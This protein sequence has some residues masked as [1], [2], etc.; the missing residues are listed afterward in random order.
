[1]LDFD[2]AQ[3]RLIQAATMPA[4]SER[5]P[6]ERALGR[7][8]AETVYA[9]LDIP[10]ADNSA[11][12]G[13]AIRHAETQLD[14]PMPIQDHIY[15]GDEPMP[16]KPK[17]AIRLFTG[18]L[19]PDGADTVVMQEHCTEIEGSVEINRLPPAGANVRFRGEDMAK[20]QTIIA[21]GQTLNSR[22]L[23]ILA[24]QGCTHIDVYPVPKIGILSTGDE[25]INP[26]Q[27]LREGQIYNSNSPMLKGMIDALGAEAT[28][29]I[30][31]PD[32]IEA[33]QEALRQLTDSCD[34]VLTVGGV[35]VGDKDFVKP[36]IEQMGGRM[37]LWR[38][39]M[40]PGR[41]VTLAQVR[42]TP[43]IGLPGNPVSAYAIFLLMVSPL[44]RRLQ[45]RT[46]ILPPVFY[47]QLETDRQF[48]GP[49]EEFLRV[50]AHPKNDGRLQLI[51]HPK[52][53][54]A[55]ISSLAWASGLA[56]I[57]ADQEIK[58]GDTVAYY[59]F[60]LWGQ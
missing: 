21:Q 3:D 47:G 32:T 15:A 6:V 43:V 7:I 2:S 24:T 20:D 51:A 17:Q 18:S 22:H 16:L 4:R 19:M 27:P 40:K 8:N 36:A 10:P 52:Q 33:I 49:R 45:G 1:M 14:E 9:N 56:R 34:V 57:P 60:S 48:H 39:R 35:S 55:M 37:D 46:L 28:A 12:D 41:P 54:S 31:A 26:G 42:R 44:I 11:M 58:A 23:A 38:V 5:I 50:Q 53:G 25:L 30:H 29:C 59:D 13:Y